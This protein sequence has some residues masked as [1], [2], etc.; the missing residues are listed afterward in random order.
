M[1]E[2]LNF[3]SNSKKED[4]IIITSLT[5]KTAMPMSSEEKRTWLN[6]LVGEVLDKIKPEASLGSR[7][8]R[9]IPV[10]EVK[11]DSSEL[12]KRIRKGFGEKKIWS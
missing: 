9:V 4:K 1:R 2:E 10:V 3:I 6:T 7:N 5:S 8:S 12:A 11:L